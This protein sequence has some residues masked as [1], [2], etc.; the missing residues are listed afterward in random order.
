MKQRGDKSVDG[1]ARFYPDKKTVGRVLVPVK[2]GKTIGPN[3]VRDLTGTVD[4]QKGQMGVLI[5]MADPPRGIIDAANHRGTCTWPVNGQAF[6][7]IQV[8]TVAYLLSR[9][10]PDMPPPR[11]LYVQATRA[12]L[13]APEQMTLDGEAAE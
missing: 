13:P 5:S 11:L 9:K 7:R 2:G 6:P 1:V 10:R 4:S 8:I 3:F 12:A